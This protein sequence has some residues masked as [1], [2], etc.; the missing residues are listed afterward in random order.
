M[1]PFKTRPRPNLW[2]GFLSL[3]PEKNQKGAVIITHT[4][5][6]GYLHKK[7]DMHI[8]LQIHVHVIH[9]IYT[10]TMDGDISSG[11]KNKFLISFSYLL[12]NNFEDFY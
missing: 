3:I 7:I 12:N 4:Q 1:I 11:E 2:P 9:A 10:C 5:M 6:L 8:C